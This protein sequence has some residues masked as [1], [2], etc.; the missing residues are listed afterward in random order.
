MTKAV[1]I[2]LNINASTDAWHDCMAPVHQHLFGHHTHLQLQQ[3]QQQ[4]VFENV[5]TALHLNRRLQDM[6]E[7]HSESEAEAYDDISQGILDRLL[8]NTARPQQQQQQG[9]SGSP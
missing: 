8:C 3:Q 5:L 2:Y 6:P 9:G 4:T 7:P 1:K